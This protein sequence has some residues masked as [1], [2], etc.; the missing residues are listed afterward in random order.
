MD[1]MLAVIQHYPDAITIFV[2][3][4]TI[5]ELEQRLRARGTE[6][7]LAIQRRLEVARHELTYASRYQHKVINDSVDQAVA[8]ICRILDQLIPTQTPS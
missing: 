5:E 6:T 3:P 2:Q 4:S 1:G 8:D 7:E